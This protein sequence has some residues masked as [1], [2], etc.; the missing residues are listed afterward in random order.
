MCPSAHERLHVAVEEREQ[1]RSDVL[2]VDV[3]VGHDDDLIVAKAAISRTGWF[4]SDFVGF[5]V[6]RRREGDSR[7]E[8]GDQAA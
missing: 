7:A 8:S 6:A 4:D 3:R 5:G 1:K 2:A